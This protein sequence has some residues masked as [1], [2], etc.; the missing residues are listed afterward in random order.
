[1]SLLIRTD[2]LWDLRQP[3]YHDGPAWA[4][5]DPPNLTHNYRREAGSQR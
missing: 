2:R 3:I 1:M 4:D 5:Y